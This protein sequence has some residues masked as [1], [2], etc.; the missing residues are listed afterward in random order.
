MEEN[1][2]KSKDVVILK[3][4]ASMAI[5]RLIVPLKIIKK[6]RIRRVSQDFRLL[7]LPLEIFLKVTTYLNVN[8]IQNLGMTCKDLNNLVARSFV[9]RVVLPLSERNMEL[10]GGPNGRF[11]LSLRSNVNIR[12]W[13]WG[14][15][16]GFEEM[17]KKMN[18]TYLKE[19]QFV[20][21]NYNYKS[22]DGG[23]LIT[24]YKSVMRNIFLEKSFIRRLDISIDSSEECFS[25]LKRL[26]E[27]SFLEEL[28][29]RSS[30]FRWQHNI[31]MPN[32]I[33]LN[34][35]LKETLTGLPIRGLELK[36][37]SMP[38]SDSGRFEIE[39]F[40]KSIQTLK[41][42]CNK[43]CELTAIE[44]E[45]LKEITII[46]DYHSFCFYH[47][48]SMLDGW[49]SHDPSD[50]P[51]RLAGILAHGCPSLEKYNGMDLKALGQNGSWLA[52]LK[53]HKGEGLDKESSEAETCSQCNYQ[54]KI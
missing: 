20:G 34:K 36:G 21:K 28:C 48:Q 44:A 8:D 35:L 12:L 18:L 6:P 22:I 10:L 54:S 42:Q 53:H 33:P 39:I 29:L 5:K 26:K 13:G 45:N 51:G 7:F 30:D 52:E 40:S 14:S 46:T 16:G 23:G 4:D 19:V 32:E 38:W 31:I 43:N 50:P 47:A 24:A 11:V 25:Q 3:A 41:L 9:P 27:M 2:L 1:V 15:E 37:F 17:L 49:L